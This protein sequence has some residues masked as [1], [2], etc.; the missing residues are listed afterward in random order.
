MT[1]LLDK[2]AQV[3]LATHNHHQQ[4]TT[5]HVHSVEGPLVKVIRMVILSFQKGSDFKRERE[6]IILS[7]GRHESKE[8]LD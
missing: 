1:S 3:P 8:Q 6:D 7:L 4:L 5:D 2:A